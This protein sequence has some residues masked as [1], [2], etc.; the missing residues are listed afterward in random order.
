M[1]AALPRGSARRGRSQ[2]GPTHARLVGAVVASWCPSFVPTARRTFVPGTPS[3]CLDCH[4]VLLTLRTNKIVYQSRSSRAVRRHR[5]PHEHQCPR[6]PSAPVEVGS[7]FY[8]SCIRFHSSITAAHPPIHTIKQ[9]V[10]L[11]AVSKE[12]LDKQRSVLG[13][14]EDLLKLRTTNKTNDKVK[15]MR[16]RQRAIVPRI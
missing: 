4:L 12:K 9:T 13:R 3:L 7:V 10:Q 5:A 16:M 2:S 1:P 8:P 14:I 6:D 11:R 15:L